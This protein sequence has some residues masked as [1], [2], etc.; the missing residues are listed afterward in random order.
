MSRPYPTLFG[1]EAG[2]D[3]QV[4]VIGVPYDRGTPPEQGGG[5]CRA[6]Q[7]LRRLSAPEIIQVK[8]GLLFDLERRQ[9]IFK[10]LVLSDLGDIRYRPE[11]ADEEYREFITNTASLIVAERKAPLFLGG[12]HLIALLA[13]RGLARAGRSVQ[14]LH[15]DA[16]LDY[17]PVKSDDLPTHSTFVSFIVTEGLAQRVIQIGSRGISWGVPPTPQAVISTRVSELHTALLPGVDL[18]LTIDTDVFDTSIAPAV[19]FPE[20]GGLTLAGLTDVLQVVQAA[21]LRA[22]GADW[23]EYN[24][25]LDRDNFLTGRLVLSGLS[26][27]IGFLS[28]GLSQ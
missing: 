6:P 11:R 14:V 15:L 26:Q 1:C 18:Y 19:N 27:V 2:A 8:N 4:V 7:C 13:L 28:R 17:E 5:C 9:E 24:P 20:P 23:S 21:G 12:D 3:G 10:G 22:I 25:V 16:H